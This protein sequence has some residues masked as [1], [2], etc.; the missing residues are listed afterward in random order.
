MPTEQLNLVDIWRIKNLGR[1]SCTW[2]QKSPT[3]LCRFDLWLISN[4]LF[5]FVN[6]TEVLPAI[7]T[8]HA[9]ISLALGEI[10]DIESPSMWKMNVS[11]LDNEEYLNFLK[12]IIHQ[13]GK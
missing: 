4:N 6:S 2:S 11:L 5:D 13:S 8:D 3:V 10:G 12:K 7:S 1:K 9:A